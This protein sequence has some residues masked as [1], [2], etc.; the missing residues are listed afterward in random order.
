[1][2]FNFENGVVSVGDAVKVSVDF[3]D[4]AENGDFVIIVDRSTGDDMEVRFEKLGFVDDGGRL[5]SKVTGVEHKYTPDEVVGVFNGTYLIETTNQNG[6]TVISVYNNKLEKTDETVLEGNWGVYD[7]SRDT[8]IAEKMGDVEDGEVYLKEYTVG[9]TGELEFVEEYEFDGCDELF[10][11]FDDYENEGFDNEDDGFDNEDDDWEPFDEDE[12]D[13]SE[14]E[15]D[16]KEE[17]EGF[18][19]EE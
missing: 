16:S 19:D 11:D 7:F 13:M 10:D 18:D 4:V 8:I 2:N 6:D 3:K 5:F 17:Y 9:L 1:M 12:E 14:Y 15:I